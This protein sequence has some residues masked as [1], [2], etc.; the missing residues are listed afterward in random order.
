[1]LECMVCGWQTWKSPV[2]LIRHFIASHKHLR[3]GD[4]YMLGHSSIGEEI[5]LCWC[6]WHTTV[7]HCHLRA[8]EVILQHMMDNG[9]TDL[10][11]L[12]C[13]LGVEHE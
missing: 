1:M 13:M 7:N 2:N 10:H 9:G 4:N 12:A 6:G 3:P 5:V 11:T 8:D